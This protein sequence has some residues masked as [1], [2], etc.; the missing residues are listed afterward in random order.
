MKSRQS[1]PKSDSPYD[2]AIRLLARREHS[3]QEIEHKLR[4]RGFA[5]DDIDE[6]L[7][8]LLEQGLL[9]DQRFT[10]AYVN[11]RRNRGFGP[12][13]IAAELYQRGISKS[14]AWEAIQSDADYWQALL[15]EVYERKFGSHRADDLADKARRVK[16]LQNRGFPLDWAMKIVQ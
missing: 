4:Q 13:R 1:K 3:Q 9:S 11:S 8:T 6:T 16:F 7:E 5:G 12:Q 2:A 10:E 14:M 15:Q